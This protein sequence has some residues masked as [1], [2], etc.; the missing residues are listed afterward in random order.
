MDESESGKARATPLLPK[1]E[2][3]PNAKKVSETCIV[4]IFIAQL[5]NVVALALSKE[6]MM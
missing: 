2:D 5:L 4:L 6:A 1:K 3:K